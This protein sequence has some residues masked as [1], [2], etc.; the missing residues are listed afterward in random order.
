[1]K[2]LLLASTLVG[3]TI[4]LLNLLNIKKKTT[5]IATH[6]P[7]AKSMESFIDKN[8]S[9][10]KKEQTKSSTKKNNSL[11]NVDINKMLPC[12]ALKFVSKDKTPWLYLKE[13]N[14]SKYSDMINSLSDLENFKQLSKK[15]KKIL[16][17]QIN[18][19]TDTGYVPFIY[20]LND[21]I[22]NSK[23][24][25]DLKTF[26]SNYLYS[27]LLGGFTNLN[28]DLYLVKYLISIK[29]YKQAKAKIKEISARKPKT[30]HT[31]SGIRD[32]I[33]RSAKT[34]SEM[35]AAIETLSRS[36]TYDVSFLISLKENTKVNISQF[37]LDKIAEKLIAET[38]DY[39]DPQD[40]NYLSYAVALKIHSKGK[41][42][43]K[44][45]GS[46]EQL[47]TKVMLD[48]SSDNSRSCDDRE[49]INL[50][51]KYCSK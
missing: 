33:Y 18:Q 26:F 37:N 29:D 22:I 41:L 19:F 2:K 49:L 44:K 12:E 38:L 16:T 24:S 31:I 10:K 32:N 17:Q 40:I 3:I 14:Y 8:N 45:Y 7:I 20:E 34:P 25:K 36:P 9:N 43:E 23:A 27:S 51:E 28:D 42:L 39:R 50:C 30:S 21:K 15:K 13:N 46:Q 47:V 1:M 6:I 35:A 4:L 11:L 48:N 5:E